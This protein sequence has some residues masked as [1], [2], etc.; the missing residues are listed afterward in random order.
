MRGQTNRPVEA[1]RRVTRE[2]CVVPVAVLLGTY[3]SIRVQTRG[4]E[5]ARN[6]SRNTRAILSRTPPI[7]AIKADGRGDAA[8]PES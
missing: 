5:V 6:P 1:V 2:I 3:S 8:A 4:Q 7:K